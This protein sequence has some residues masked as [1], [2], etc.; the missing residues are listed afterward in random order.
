M[1]DAIL[2]Q[3][4]LL[5]AFVG[6]SLV[7]ALTPGPAVVY[8]IARTVAQGRACGLASVF[9]VALGNLGN[10]L[11]AALG[12]AALLLLTVVAQEGAA[13]LAFPPARL[14]HDLSRLGVVLALA[15]LARAALGRC[16]SGL[17]PGGLVSRGHQLRGLAQRSVLLLL[18]FVLTGTP[19]L[20][21]PER[22]A[23]LRPAL[24]VSLVAG[25]I[26]AL[27]GRATLSAVCLAHPAGRAL[28]ALPASPTTFRCHPGAVSLRDAIARDGA[29]AQAG[30]GVR[31]GALVCGAPVAA[32]LR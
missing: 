19:I 24:G 12:L 32:G 10:A 8:I 22:L 28:R 14:A 15:A 9:G 26:L 30:A 21:G 2:P 6:A 29:G 25:G 20:F 17:A 13:R 3:T 7:L 11:G 23:V 27:A 16:R 18:F 4:P 5:L 31:A 1:L